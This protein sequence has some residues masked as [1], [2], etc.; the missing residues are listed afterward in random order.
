MLCE[1]KQSKECHNCGNT[2]IRGEPKTSSIGMEGLYF[3]KM[4]ELYNENT[5]ILQ[6]SKLVNHNFSKDKKN[7]QSYTSNSTQ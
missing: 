1:G 4:V 3:G 6:L 7:A 5:N 2:I